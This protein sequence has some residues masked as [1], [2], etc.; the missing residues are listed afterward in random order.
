MYITVCKESATP[1][2]TKVWWK[3]YRKLLF[4]ILGCVKKIPNILCAT[5]HW[6]HILVDFHQYYTCNG[7]A[8][9]WKKPWVVFKKRPL[10]FLQLLFRKIVPHFSFH[11]PAWLSIFLFAEKK[12]KFSN[13]V[14]FLSCTCYG[15]TRNILE[16][17]PQHFWLLRKI[18]NVM[19]F[20]NSH[21]CSSLEH[22]ASIWVYQIFCHILEISHKSRANFFVNR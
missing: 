20:T 14:Y 1:V 4:S 3:I 12:S 11:L 18:W 8:F 2:F 7:R 19:K 16:L 13:W 9:S 17:F 21:Y 5:A 22:N 6:H 10:F 15:S